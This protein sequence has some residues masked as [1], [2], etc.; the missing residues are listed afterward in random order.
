MLATTLPAVAASATAGYLLREE[1]GGEDQD[2]EHENRVQHRQMPPSVAHGFPVSI[3]SLAHTLRNGTL[4]E[5]WGATAAERDARYPCDDVLAEPDQSLWRAVRV[6]APAPLVWRW[7]CQ[8]RVAHDQLRPHGV[9]RRARRHVPRRPARRR[10]ITHRRQAA[11]SLPG[12]GTR[13][14]APSDASDRRS[15]D[16]AQAAAHAEGSRRARRPA[17]SAGR[18]A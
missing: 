14:A 10:P 8:L 9:R 1:H 6:D 15:R 4:G 12:W 16:D 3:H 13:R 7:V 17:L 2:D 11:R 18:Y 5:S